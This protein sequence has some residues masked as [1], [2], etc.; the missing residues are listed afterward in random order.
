[1][2]ATPSAGSVYTKQQRIA[3]LARTAPE[4]AFT[5]LAHH[6]DAEWLRE[7]YRRV[8]KDGAVGVDGQTAVEY[9]RDLAGNLESLLNRF[10]SGSYRAPPVRR[11]HIPKGD[12]RTRPIGIPT[13]EDKILQRAVVMLLEPI[14]EQ[15]FMDCSY[16]FRPGKS[17]H[18]ALEALWK[19]LMD[20]GGGWVLE[21]DIRSFFDSVDHAQLRSILDGRV[22]DGVVRRAI[23]KWLKAGVSENGAVTHP[24]LGT[25]QGGVISPLLAN[26]YLHEVLDEWF[27]QQ[28]RPRLRGNAVLI[29]YADDF[30]IVFEQEDDARRVQAVLVKRFAKYGLT[31][32]PEKTRLLDFRRP[33]RR[34]DGDDHDGGPR[35]RGL[36]LLGFTHFWGLSR[37]GKWVVRRKTAS[38]RLRRSVKR[39]ADW[40]RA[41]RH[42]AVS[43]QHGK[44]SQKVSGHYAYF[45]ITGNARSLGH[46]L[47]AVER[48]WHKWLARRSRVGMPWPRFK[49]LLQ[50]LPL[51]P[52]RVVHSTYLRAAN[53]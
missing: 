25:P 42:D 40:C 10:K 38:S 53:P 7:A 21:V 37:R 17:A 28:V 39:I 16:G 36:D 32:H 44:L 5:T 45:G 12:G 13:L 18:M 34:E 3:E 46:F 8:R 43:D 23:D 30:V 47:H 15:D 4:L 49:H 20:L 33:T 11:V 27:A 24:D 31:L 6:V 35:P 29:R 22:R 52:V 19:A 26:V 2:S 9:E 50:R 48:V 14:Y 41:H 51:P 1:M